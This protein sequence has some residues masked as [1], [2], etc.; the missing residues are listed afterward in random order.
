MQ[1]LADGKRSRGSDVALSLRDVTKSYA[2]PVSTGLSR[3]HRKSARL[4][5]LRDISFDVAHAQT[6]GILGRNGAGKSTLLKLIS[7]VTAPDKGSVYV[8]GRVG[9][10][11]EVGTGF[12]PELTGRENVYMNAAVLGMRKSAVDR[13]F[14]NIVGFAE[15][16]HAIDKPLKHY[17]SGMQVRLG[18]SVAAHLDCEVLLMDE[19]LAVGDAPFQARCVDKLHQ[20]C[21]E[22][23]RTALLV[24][25][26]MAP[27][28]RLANRV[29]VI[30]SGRIA[31]DGGPGEGIAHYIRSLQ[32]EFTT[33]GSVVDLTRRENMF[34]RELWFESV[35]AC[36][37][38]ATGSTREFVI[39]LRLMSKTR[40][41]LIVGLRVSDNVGMGLTSGLA[42]LPIIDEDLQGR[43]IAL[44]VSL[45]LASVAPGVYFLDMAI[46]AGL[47]A[48]LIDQVQ[49]AVS[50]NCD[51]TEP[52]QW[53]LRFG[54]ARVALPIESSWRIET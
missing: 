32:G 20:L 7:R 37:P 25:H 11:L 31:F 45:P 35:E 51:V 10:L 13:R 22:E 29:L 46:S 34:G 49:R 23:G 4:E 17:S 16:A 5:V 38:D 47:G 28:A 3:R 42:E 39:R 12:H 9:S 27:V 15:V 44:T 8:D 19:V 18:F 52:E 43:T 14:D 40:R 33:D 48:P 21:A 36:L 26:A 41:E 2:P 53:R 54:D 50:I 1:G 6:V 24:S 30:D